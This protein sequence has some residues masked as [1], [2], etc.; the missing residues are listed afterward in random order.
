MITP[1]ELARR[2]GRPDPTAEQAAAIAAP[3]E[4]GVVVAGAGSGKT[5]TMASRVSSAT[6]MLSGW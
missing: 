1:Q 4:P 3:L 6:N 5:D 2:L